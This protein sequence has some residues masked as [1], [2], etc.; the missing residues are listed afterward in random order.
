MAF[1]GSIAQE[2]FE[3]VGGSATDF[4][5]T[6]LCDSEACHEGPALVFPAYA[7]YF[8]LITLLMVQTVALRD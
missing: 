5:R 3:L 6:K 8:Y 7:V 1:W 4:S 2:I